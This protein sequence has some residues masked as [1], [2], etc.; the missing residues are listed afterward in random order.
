[1]SGFADRRTYLYQGQ[2][3]DQQ[4]HLGFDL[5]SVV[6][7]PIEATQNGIVVLAENLGIYGNT[8]ILDHGLGV[9]SLYG[10]LSS[11]AVQAGQRVKRAAPLGQSGETGLAGGDHLHFSI[12]VQGVHVDP[13]EWW[14]G[15]W[16]REHVTSELNLLPSAA[17]AA[18]AKAITTTP[19]Q[20]A[21]VAKP[22]GADERS[23]EQAQP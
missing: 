16:V 10:H 6:R 1:M 23:H 21:P 13:R 20:E 7:A 2:A 18:A 8:V 19:G 3:I 11:I 5:A 17:A 4:T 14:D 12:M 9:F 15:K 22:D